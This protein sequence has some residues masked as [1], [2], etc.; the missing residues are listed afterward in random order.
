MLGPSGRLEVQPGRN[1][2]ISIKGWSQNSVLVRARVE[3]WAATDADAKVVASQV[4]VETNGGLISATGPDANG[5][6]PDG[7][8]E[9]WSVS[10]EIF[11]P[12]NTDL[13]LESH[14]GG[15]NVSDVRGRIEFQSHNGGVRLARVA[16]D[17]SGETHNG[18]IQADLQGN[19]WDGRQLELSTYNGAITL[20]M[21]ASYSAS[22]ET[23]SYRGAVSSDFPVSATGRIDS[24]DLRFNVGAGGQLIKMTTHN[25]GIRL[26]KM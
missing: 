15:I 20:S 9:G 24:G 1:G 10:F 3:I 6:L 2:G 21:P 7:R 19:A 11:T 17:V 25:G 18:G 22:L 4:H 5:A 23:H 16:G 14:N 13:K 12:L 26:R 8:D